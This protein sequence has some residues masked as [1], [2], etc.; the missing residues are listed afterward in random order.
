M[1]EDEDRF[2]RA[3]AI[4]RDREPKLIADHVARVATPEIA[5]SLLLDPREL[6][7]TEVAKLFAE[8][9]RTRCFSAAFELGWHWLARDEDELRDWQMSYLEKVGDNLGDRAS[10]FALN[11]IAREKLGFRFRLS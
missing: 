6:E 7:R 9:A 2:E 11:K 8:Y 4:F 3:L 5:Q 1:T 10:F